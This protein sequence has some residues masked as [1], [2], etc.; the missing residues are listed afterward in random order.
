MIELAL[1][2]IRDISHIPGLRD[3]R[4]TQVWIPLVGQE[5]VQDNP[6][7]RAPTR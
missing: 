2:G 3:K 4:K 5:L 6:V 7:I 1:C